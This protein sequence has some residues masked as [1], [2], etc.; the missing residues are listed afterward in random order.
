MGIRRNVAKTSSGG[1]QEL[2]A[3]DLRHQLVADYAHLVAYIAKA[4]AAK[5]P[6]S[7][8]FNDLIGAGFLG[9]VDAIEK[10][11]IGLG[12]TFR[13]YAEYRIRGAILDELRRLD[14]MPR[15]ARQ[16][17]KRMQKSIDQLERALGRPSTSIER[18]EALN[19]SITRYHIIMRDLTSFD[20]VDVDIEGIVGRGITPV[21][22]MQNAL[23]SESRAM[24]RKLIRRLNAQ[25]QLV[26][27]LYVFEGL[28][29]AEIG[30][31]IGV[32]ESRASQ[33][34][35]GAIARLRDL[36]ESHPDS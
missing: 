14:T 19:L 33:I 23:D 36:A 3:S 31:L 2:L 32:S 5:V 1:T 30:R 16:R 34:Y 29:L 22:P 15:S 28:R 20:A 12:N 11:D 27:G 17:I 4:I 18:A 24:I 7:V 13:T 8:D 25:Q 26:I 21:D 6:P 9:L 10:F 35:S